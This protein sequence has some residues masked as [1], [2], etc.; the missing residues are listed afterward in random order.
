MTDATH[1]P[2]WL[3]HRVTLQ[4]AAGAPDGAGGETV[5]WDD[6][7]TLWARIA[8]TAAREEIVGGHLAGVVTHDITFRWRD[9]IAGGMRV[10]YRDRVFRLLAVSD[11]D[12]RRR[13][14]V[15]KA[16]EETP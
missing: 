3:R 15:A 11:P 6:M 5:T 12:E 16:R 14:V 7:A 2:G 4:S 9:D 1:D 10:V 8:P 13:Y